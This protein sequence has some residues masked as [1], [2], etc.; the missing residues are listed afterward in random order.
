MKLVRYYV[1]LLLPFMLMVACNNKEEENPRQ[2]LA[3]ESSKTWIANRE[4]DAAGDEQRL[5]D[6]EREQKMVFYANGAFQILNNAEFQ[7]GRWNYNE[8]QKELEITFDDRQNVKEVFH[9]QELENDK[10]VLHASDGSTMRM[11]PE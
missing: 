3:S 4:T 5:N 8:A 9:V 7:T 1:L 11:K 2:L 6:D 10:L